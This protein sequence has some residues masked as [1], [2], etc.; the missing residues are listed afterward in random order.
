[1]QNTS[2]VNF[3]FKCHR[4]PIGANPDYIDI[5][6]VCNHELKYYQS[7]LIKKFSGK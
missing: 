5:Y 2:K 4:R 1:M 7:N 6:A 3:T